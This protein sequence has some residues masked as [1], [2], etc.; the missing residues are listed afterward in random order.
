MVCTPPTGT[1]TL[2]GLNVIETVPTLLV[3]LKLTEFE[4]PPPGPGLVTVMADTPCVERTDGGA[5]AESWELEPYVVCNGVPPKETIEEL[6]KPFPEIK[7]VIGPEPTGAEFGE[8]DVIAGT[9]F[10]PVPVTTNGRA[11]DIAPATLGSVTVTAKVPGTDNPAAGTVA[12]K[13]CESVNVVIMGRP[14]NE[15]MSAGTKFDP[16]KA[17]VNAGPPDSVWLGAN[18]DKLGVATPTE[19]G[20]DAWRRTWDLSKIFPSSKSP[21]L[22]K[23]KT[24]ALRPTGPSSPAVKVHQGFWVT[25]AENCR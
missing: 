5:V 20:P 25:S 12:D 2:D 8:M 13:S 15:I 16:V 17:S 18:E 3:T 7:R 9:G 23:P 1:D 22:R 24:S 21:R 14:L 4:V 6:I 10:D 11:F 19:K